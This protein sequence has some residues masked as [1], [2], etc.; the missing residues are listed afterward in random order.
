MDQAAVESEGDVLRCLIFEAN[1][2]VVEARAMKMQI[3][4]R[5]GWASTN[6]PSRGME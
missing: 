4:E 3:R 5:M 1:E 6:I 2:V